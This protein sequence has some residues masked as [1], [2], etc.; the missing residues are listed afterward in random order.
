MLLNISKI[1]EILVDLE[2]R[3]KLFPERSTFFLKSI[4][5]VP[6]SNYNFPCSQ[7][8]DVNEAARKVIDVM[9][10]YNLTREDWESVMEIGKLGSQ[11]DIISSI[12]SKVFLDFLRLSLSL[13][14]LS[15]FTLFK[16]GF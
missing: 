13:F 9:D 7:G 5:C 6:I 3:K 4:S 11:S 15:S 2:K 12:P 10:A 14:L 8:D 1:L 16:V